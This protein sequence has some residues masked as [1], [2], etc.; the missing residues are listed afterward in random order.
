MSIS[1]DNGSASIV[2]GAGTAVCRAQLGWEKTSET[3]T[4]VTYKL[5]VYIYCIRYGYSTSG[6]LSASLSCSGHT[7]KSVSGQSCNLSAGS[8]KQLISNTS[9]T[10]E[11]K[12]SSYSPTISYKVKS[13]GSS[14]S[15]TSTGTFSPTIPALASYNVT[16]NNNGGS[17]SISTQKKY[18]GKSLTLS[19]GTALSKTNCTLVGWNTNNAGTGTHYALGA[20]YTKNNALSLYAE[21]K[22]NYIKPKVTGLNCFRVDTSTST[23][24]TDDG[25]WIRVSFNYT[26]GTLNG[27]TS[28]ITP[29]CV[30]TIDGTVV[31]QAS[32]LSSA[33]GSFSEAYGGSY[34]E[35]ASHSVSVKLYDSNNTTGV[36]YTAT[37]STKTY[38]IDLIGDGLD[39]WM[40]VMTPAESG[41]PLVTAPLKVK[42]DINATG[43]V[44]NHSKRQTLWIG[45]FSSGSIS[46]PDISKYH[47]FEI[48]F[49]GI[50][51]H[52][53]CFSSGSGATG[54]LRGANS[55]CTASSVI[56]YIVGLNLNYNTE[57]LSWVNC[58]QRSMSISNKTVSSIS[59]VTITSIIGIE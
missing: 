57:T 5:G 6:A 55:Y 1:Y 59:A 47:T 52:A 7:S 24:E 9:Y 11:K 58:V 33:T 17:G 28:Y 19:K 3:S 30:I 41:T 20:T 12:T 18:Y 16:Y 26:G 34:S 2:S 36:T 22:L 10:F 46:V 8:R 43:K 51:T 48:T 35:D 44:N 42:G 23:E 31:R 25:Q 54:Y 39:V 27:G 56:D 53:I 32:A 14:V 29:T 49:N 37:V 15:G 4:S 21:W 45:S 40:G 13:T 50:A 38:P